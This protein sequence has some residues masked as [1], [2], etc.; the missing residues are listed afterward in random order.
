MPWHHLD[1]EL[2][3]DK[4]QRLKSLENHALAS[5]K[6]KGNPERTNKGNATI[7]VYNT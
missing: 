2:W 3:T 5:K 6:N 4:S 7:T 1:T